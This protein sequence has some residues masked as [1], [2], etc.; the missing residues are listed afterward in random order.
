MKHRSIVL[1]GTYG[2]LTVLKDLG[3]QQVSQSKRSR[4]YQ[5]RCSCGK[6]VNVPGPLIGKNVKSCGCLQAETRAHDIP[7]GTVFGNLTVIEKTDQKKHGTFMYRCRCSCEKGTELL[8]RSDMLRSG[9]VESCGCLHDNLLRENA[10]KAYENCFVFDTNISKI[11]S[12]KLQSNNTSGVRGVY[13]HKHIGRWNARIQFQGKAYSLG[14]FKDIQ[15]AAAA[16]KIAEKELHGDFLDWYKK[17]YPE[18]W[19]RKKAKEKTN[20][21]SD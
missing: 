7:P 19:E 1:G 11:K 13:W 6:I 18:R 4:V 15:E 17:A 12:N 5:C 3:V 2:R 20:E 8:V 9:D 14:Y 21:K 10:K 16:R